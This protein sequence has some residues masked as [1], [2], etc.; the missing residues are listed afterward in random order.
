MV[1]LFGSYL[2]PF[3][4]GL[5][6]LFTAKTIGSAMCYLITK[7]FFSVERQKSFL[8][9]S[10]ISSFNEVIE[11]SPIFYGTLVRYSGIPTSFKNYGLAAMNISFINY[12]ICCFLGSVVFVPL[13]AELGQS[14]MRVLNGEESGNQVWVTIIVLVCTGF[15]AK[16]FTGRILSKRR[17][18]KEIA[19]QKELKEK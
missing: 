9:N 10:T 3:P 14:L 12:L 13:Q 15:L 6:M 18:E 11:Q 5:T 16:A 17:K 19:V 7:Y 8:S 1:D 2:Y 4:Y